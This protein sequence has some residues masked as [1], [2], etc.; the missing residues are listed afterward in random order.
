MPRFAQ[1]QEN[2][3]VAQREVPPAAADEAARLNEELAGRGRVLVRPSGTEPVVR[4]LAEAETAEEAK[5][6]CASIARLVR[7]ESP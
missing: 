1:A 5:R 4:V 2:V 6:L 3:R 7:D